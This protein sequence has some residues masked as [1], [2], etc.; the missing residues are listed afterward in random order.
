MG[1]DRATEPL[2]AWGDLSSAASQRVVG[3]PSR[4]ASR[5]ASIGVP[6]TIK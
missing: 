1:S 6:K 4:R 2:A 3:Y 5:A